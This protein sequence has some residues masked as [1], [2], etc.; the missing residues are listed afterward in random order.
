M[1][2][3]PLALVDADQKKIKPNKKLKEPKLE[4]VFLNTQKRERIS[5]QRFNFPSPDQKQSRSSNASK[6]TVKV[7]HSPEVP[8][9]R[10][11]KSK[12]IKVE[13]SEK[14][15]DLREE[16]KVLKS[17]LKTEK[18]LKEIAI[19]QVEELETAT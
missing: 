3:N 5:T 1:S 10:N 15:A 19:R 17:K 9:G 8:K 4:L 6:T 14:T 2:T 11:S 13:D 7:E 12:P 18:T 16:L